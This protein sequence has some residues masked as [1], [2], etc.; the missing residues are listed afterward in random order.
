[1]LFW[2]E[3]SKSRNSAQIVNSDV[4]L[5]R[6]FVAFARHYFGVADEGFRVRCSLFADHES[7]QREIEQFWLDALGLPRVCLTQSV[8]N[9]YSRSS[10]RTRQNRLPYG[11][12]RITIHDVRI[13]QHLYGAIQE[14]GRFERPEWLD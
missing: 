5:L 12:C 7:R 3:G 14:Y 9:R 13:V 4:E 8:V 2:G 10:G 1:M 11:T 6:L